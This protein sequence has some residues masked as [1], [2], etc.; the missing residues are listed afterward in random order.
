MTPDELDALVERLRDWEY[1]TSWGE[2]TSVTEEAASAIVAL[3]AECVASMAEIAAGRKRAE[4]A[5]AEAKT[6]WQ[7]GYDDGHHT[8]HEDG[9]AF[10]AIDGRNAALREAANLLQASADEADIHS[11][12]TLRIYAAAILALIDKKEPTNG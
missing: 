10:G 7:D 11:A 8:G 9:Y 2:K 12:Q 5:E 3:Q 4:K 1:Y 6:A